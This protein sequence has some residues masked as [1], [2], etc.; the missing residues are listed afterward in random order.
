MIAEPAELDEV[1]ASFARFD[2][3]D[4][5][6]GNVEVAG[7]F[8]LR[9]AGG[10]ADGGEALPEEAVF[11]GVG[12]FPHCTDFRGGVGCTQNRDNRRSARA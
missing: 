3:G 9:E 10:F 6:V 12:R 5:G 8:A 1:D 7:E 2:F 11:G 4:P